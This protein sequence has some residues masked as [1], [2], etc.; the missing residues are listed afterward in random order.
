M[1]FE[2]DFF[3]NEVRD[4]F[5]VSSMMKRAWA[6]QIEVLE[7]FDNLCKE[8]NIR[9][10]AAYG[11]T[12][13]AARH[14]GFI[15]WDDDIDIC[16]LREDYEKLRVV[17]KEGK[18]P[19]EYVLKSVYDSDDYDA[20]FDRIINSYSIGFNE[21]RLEKYHGFPFC[22]GLDIFPMDYVPTGGKFAAFKED[23]TTLVQIYSALQENE[24]EKLSKR[25]REIIKVKYGYSINKNK[26]EANQIVRILENCIRKYCSKRE[27]NL[28]RVYGWAAK[29]FK[30]YGL[31]KSEWFDEIDYI[32]FEN[33]KIPV[34]YKYHEVLEVQYP[35]H[36]VAVRAFEDLHDY[37][38]YKKQDEFFF[39]TV[40]KR[41]AS[42]EYNQ[43]EVAQY[44]SSNQYTSVKQSLLS[45]ISVLIRIND[46]IIKLVESGDAEQIL[47]FLADSQ[48]VAIKMGN[49]LEERYEADVA[50]D[51]IADLEKYCEH[52][53]NVSVGMS[54]DSDLFIESLEKVIK[55][56][57]IIQKKI[58][59]ISTNPN[60]KIVFVFE[61]AEEWAKYEQL[62]KML[63]SKQDV[64][65]YAIPI[66]YYMMN[67]KLQ[68][69]DDSLRFE[70]NDIETDVEFIDYKTFEYES[71]D[72]I[73]KANPYDGSSVADIIPPF[74]FSENMHKY[75]KNIIHVPTLD[76]FEFDKEDV[77]MVEMSDCFVKTPSVIYSDYVLLN[78]KI[79]T[80]TYIELL[81]EVSE[82][83]N[84]DEKVLYCSDDTETVKTILKICES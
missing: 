81:K 59:N 39:E 7:V 48:D 24:D 27:E 64:R 29:G 51:I 5:F 72:C 35:N 84:W 49:V 2:E 28:A 75:C 73:I 83:V 13:G 56:A 34:P 76:I 77:Q 21:E 82:S 1:H 79:N 6:A 55:L 50:N 65:C 69:E 37:P 41:I 47:K 14:G 68:V 52:L 71:I 58:E 44:H 9:Y 54:E 80:N 17:A 45:K 30:E 78:S 42:R 3:K 10:F 38:F 18:L 46:L 19:D 31:I 67:S 63:S 15:P 4:G 62:Y 60:K 32:P 70:G 12:L 66:P 40:N 20:T 36:M 26:N 22:V 16:M 25:M 8:N 74:F 43:D 61:N 11:T 33:Y 23:V 53:Y 57:Q